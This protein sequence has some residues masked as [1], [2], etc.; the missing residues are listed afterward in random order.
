MRRV[1]S[2]VPCSSPYGHHSV[3]VRYTVFMRSLSV[4]KPTIVLLRVFGETKL[5]EAVRRPATKRVLEEVWIKW[6]PD[7]KCMSA[8]SPSS[9]L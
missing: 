2:K 5:L 1:E 6:S 9:C 4:A 3:D 7:S 8:G